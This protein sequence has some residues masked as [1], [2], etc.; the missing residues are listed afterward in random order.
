MGVVEAG[1]GVEMGVMAV[2]MEVRAVRG[3]VGVGVGAVRSG[4]KD[5]EEEEQ[6]EEAKVAEMQH[7][8]ERHSGGKRKLQEIL[9]DDDEGTVREPEMG[10]RE[11]RLDESV[12]KEKRTDN[13]GG[14]TGTRCQPVT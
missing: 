6:D 4:K 1:A 12:T 5:E 7:A 8:E 3:G 11:G 14:I 2:D 10:R 9:E 13:E